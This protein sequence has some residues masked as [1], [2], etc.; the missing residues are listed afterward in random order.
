[1]AD[2]VRIALIGAGRM[3]RVHLRALCESGEIELAGVV[4]PVSSS[5]EAVAAQ[6]HVVH[7]TVEQLLAAGR[8]DGVLIA[9]PS[10]T[11]AA[12]ARSFIAAGIPVL[13]EKPVGV[14]VQEAAEVARAAAEAEVPL[15]VGYWRRFV[16][17]LQALRARIVAG[18]LGEIYQ[19]SCMQWDHEPPSDEF[20]AHSGGM[21]IDMAVHELDQVRWLLGQEFAWIAAA[22]A[23]RA[24]SRPARDPDAAVLLAGLSGGATA[25]VSLGRRFPLADSCWL[26]V[27]GTHGYERPA[28]MWAADGERVFLAA[29]I[30]QAEAFARMIRGQPPE[31]A[32][33]ADAVAALDAAERATAA[34]E[35]T[36]RGPDTAAAAHDAPGGR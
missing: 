22:P 25:T 10:D 27:W 28:Y 23:G 4:E 15:Q 19:V 3:G 35:A 29:M 20:R 13:C 33:G 36:E 14:R 2:R 30:A 18:E 6:G 26:E 12:V 21:A 11:H 1:M 31:G 5:R 7:A 32:L 17:E 16:P 24:G 34:L 8:P 9:T